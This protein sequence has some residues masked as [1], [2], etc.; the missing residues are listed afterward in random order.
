[1]FAQLLPLSAKMQTLANVRFWRDLAYNDDGYIGFMCTIDRLFRTMMTRVQWRVETTNASPHKGASSCI[2]PVLYT[3]A[4][5]RT[6]IKS[7]CI[8]RRWTN[9]CAFC[10]LFI[11]KATAW[12]CVYVVQIPS[13]YSK[14]YAFV[15]DSFG[16]M[17]SMYYIRSIGTFVIHYYCYYFFFLLLLSF[18]TVHIIS[19]K[20]DGYSSKFVFVR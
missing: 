12:Q 5:I 20:T 2:Q 15:R 6:A 17:R 9:M 4:N 7:T 10:S 11:H 14:D 16:W 8:I 1:M 13:I 19:V 3:P 18:S